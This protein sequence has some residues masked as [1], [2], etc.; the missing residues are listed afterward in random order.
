MSVR[1]PPVTVYMTVLC[2]PMS[3]SRSPVCVTRTLDAPLGEASAAPSAAGILLLCD[4][5]VVS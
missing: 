1:A 3:H 4:T 5:G 2:S